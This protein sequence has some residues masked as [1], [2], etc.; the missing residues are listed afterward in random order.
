M[1]WIIITNLRSRINLYKAD[2]KI[3]KCVSKSG[4]EPMH[5]DIKEAP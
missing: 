5:K 4:I 3:L 2:N 1:E